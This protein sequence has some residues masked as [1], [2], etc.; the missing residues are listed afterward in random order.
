MKREKIKYETVYESAWLYTLY[1]QYGDTPVLVIEHGSILTMAPTSFDEK[2]GVTSHVYFFKSDECLSE[3]PKMLTT[4]ENV[5]SKPDKTIWLIERNDQLAIDT[6]YE[7]LNHCVTRC[8]KIIDD[9]MRMIEWYRK[10]QMALKDGSMRIDDFSKG[11]KN[12]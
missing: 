7:Y 12:G 6:Y 1:T 10:H 3:K 8:L 5:M 4:D 11:E 9:E 2:Y